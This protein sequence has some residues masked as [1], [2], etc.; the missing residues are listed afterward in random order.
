[1]NVGSVAAG[2]G[3]RC[4]PAAPIGRIGAVPQ[5]RSQVSPVGMSPLVPEPLSS[6]LA[7]VLARSK[8]DLSASFGSVPAPLVSSRFCSCLGSWCLLQPDFR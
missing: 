1:M 5:L 7:G 8:E 4:A 6:R 2:A 3:R